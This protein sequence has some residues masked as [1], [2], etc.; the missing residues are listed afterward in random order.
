MVVRRAGRRG[1]G[2]QAVN[3]AIAQ[4][5]TYDSSSGT[6]SLITYSLF[7]DGTRYHLDADVVYAYGVSA[8]LT[9]VPEPA[10]L[11]LVGAGLI[12]LAGMRLKRRNPRQ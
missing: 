12:G 2:R 9:V 7:P 3:S 6:V 4:V 5:L 8:G 11:W 10:T 1:Q